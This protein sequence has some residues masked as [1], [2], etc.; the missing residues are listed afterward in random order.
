M[1]H[2]R[3]SN[4][5]VLVERF[6]KRYVTLYNGN[7]PAETTAGTADVF[8]LELEPGKIEP[9]APFVG[10]RNWKDGQVLPHTRSATG[11]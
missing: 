5:Q 1:S 3:A 9:A 10:V 6:G 2:A 11:S 8:S 7:E 4:P